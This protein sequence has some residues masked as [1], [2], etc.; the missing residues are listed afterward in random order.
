M[1]KIGPYALI[2][3]ISLPTAAIA[4]DD[5]KTTC[6]MVESTATTIMKAR[7]NGAALSNLME[8]ADDSKFI[9]Q[10]A[11]MAYDQPQYSTPENQKNA[12]SKFANELYLACIKET[13]K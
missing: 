6:K 2:C 13:R 3:A 10:V 5:W 7:Q 1:N 4:A 9:E 12:V 8:I 11:I